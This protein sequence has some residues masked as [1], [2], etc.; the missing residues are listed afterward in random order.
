MTP[1]VRIDGIKGQ[2]PSASLNLKSACEPLGAHSARKV[3]AMLTTAE[4]TLIVAGD[5]TVGHSRN[6]HAEAFR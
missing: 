6:G 2:I 4:V 1:G 5:R 3:W